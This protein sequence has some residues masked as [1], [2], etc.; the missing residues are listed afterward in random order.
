MS[1]IEQI[2]KGLAPSYETQFQSAHIIEVLAQSTTECVAQDIEQASDQDKAKLALAILKLIDKPAHRTC[3]AKL[4]CA[5]NDL[6]AAIPH[7]F[8]YKY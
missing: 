5:K 4:E 2:L 6:E 3:A 7:I 1:D 8:A